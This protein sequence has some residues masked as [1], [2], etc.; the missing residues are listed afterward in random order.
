MFLLS[1]HAVP[2]CCPCLLTLLSPYL[3]PTNLP[4]TPHITTNQLGSPLP[5]E[6]TYNCVQ[7]RSCR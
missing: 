5:T 2:A 4:T 3:L 6:V 1:L 7:C